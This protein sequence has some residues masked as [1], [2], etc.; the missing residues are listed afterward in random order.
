MAIITIAVN[1]RIAVTSLGALLDQ[2]GAGQHLGPGAIGVLTALPAAAFAAFGAVTAR[3]SR[4]VAT[5]PLLLTAMSL[6][7]LGQVLA[8]DDRLDRDLP[9]RQRR[10]AGRDRDRQHPGPGGHQAVLPR[11]DRAGHRGLHHRHGRRGHLG[12]RGDR[13]AGGP[14]RLAGRARGLGPA[15]GDRAGAAGADPPHAAS[16]THGHGSGSHRSLRGLRCA[17]CVGRVLLRPPLRGVRRPVPLRPP[18]RGVR[19]P[20]RAASAARSASAG[21]TRLGWA[22]ALFFG[23]QSFSAYAIM[24]WLPQIYRDAGFSA[25]TS[26]LLLAGV[27]GFGGPM[28]IAMPWLAARRTDQRPLVLVLAA[29]MGVAYLGLAVAPH[30]GALVWTALLAFGQG[31]FPLVLALFG[32]RAATSAGTA[33]LSAFAQ[34]TG[35]LIAMV[36]PLSVG[37][38]YRTTGG[39]L[40]SLGVLLVALV[41]Q[42]ISG[43]RAARPGTL[44]DA[45]VANRPAEEP[46]AAR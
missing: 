42:A 17:E 27:I 32:L 21:R 41:I 46:V 45:I 14:A 37:L 7:A 8:G 10:R 2:V 40:A 18:L 16:P 39:W 25:Q 36:G 13:A 30:S 34:S 23:T 3:L 33:A 12:G 22:L 6:V 11:P 35:Y 26:G 20:V 44:E 1:L 4:R 24:S 31:S 19:R 43:L 5:T 29:A 15:G 9:R 38:L 28:A